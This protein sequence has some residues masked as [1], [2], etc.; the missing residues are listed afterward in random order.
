MQSPF[1]TM[2][3]LKTVCSLASVT[4]GLLVTCC[5]SP[6]E[7]AASPQPIVPQTETSPV[8][9][10]ERQAVADEDVIQRVSIA[11]CDRSQSCSRIGPGATY[12]DRADCMAQQRVLVS[13]QLNTERC[14]GGIGETGVARCVKS[15]QIGECDM[16]GEIYGAASH[17]KV[18]DMCIK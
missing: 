5:A 2:N 12:H 15:L 16:P 13:K 4:L 10:T 14:P 17:C 6:Q 11:R 8:G 7:T 9:V 1:L 18:A 3:T